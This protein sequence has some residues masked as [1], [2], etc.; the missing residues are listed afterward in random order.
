[1]LGSR[2][3]TSHHNL[4]PVLSFPD[5]LAPAQTV[6]SSDGFPGFAEKRESSKSMG[7]EKVILENASRPF[8]IAA[9]GLWLLSLTNSPEGSLYPAI[10]NS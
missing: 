6:L 4:P 7:L 1:M 5:R 3:L 2:E 9:L 8:P 10:N